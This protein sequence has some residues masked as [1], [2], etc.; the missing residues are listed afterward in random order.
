MTTNNDWMRDE[1]IDTAVALAARTSW[2]A[3]RLHDVADEL[4]ISLDDIRLY[5][6]EKDELV[7]AWFD[8]ADSRMLREAESAGFLD[9]TAPERVRHLIMTWLNALAVQRKVTQQMIMAKMEIGHIHIQVPAV[10][11]ISRTV[12][13]VREAAHCDATFVRRALE[14]T[15]LTTIYLMTFF[16]W[17]RDNSQDSRYTRQFLERHLSMVSWETRANHENN[18]K[19]NTASQRKQ[20]PLQFD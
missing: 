14:E 6:R 13:W 2:E 9:M 8:R 15:A 4:A 1:I 20:I 10:M 5:F 16:F 19:K 17:M 12:Q 3:L 18:T 11:R 7:D